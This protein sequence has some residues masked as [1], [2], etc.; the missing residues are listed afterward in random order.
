MTKVEWKG[1][2]RHSPEALV[3]DGMLPKGCSESSNS[4]KTKVSN[5]FRRQL[6]IEENNGK[7]RHFSVNDFKHIT[8]QII[9]HG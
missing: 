4:I 1:T 9:Y 2:T 5:E 7:S 8:K 3:V 6:C